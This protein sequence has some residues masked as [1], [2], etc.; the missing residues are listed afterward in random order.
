MA[1]RKTLIAQAVAATFGALAVS[2][3]FGDTAA[4]FAAPRYSLTA[5][6]LSVCGAALVWAVFCGWLL[7]FLNAKPDAGSVTDVYWTDLVGVIG[8]LGAFI[9]GSASYFLLPQ[10]LGVPLLIASFVLLLA[11]FWPKKPEAMS[12]KEFVRKIAEDEYARRLRRIDP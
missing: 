8:L 12:N 10:G 11:A 4:E 6:L 5:A 1:S 7:G 3:L 2:V 9:W